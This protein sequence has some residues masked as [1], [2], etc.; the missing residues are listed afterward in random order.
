MRY[1]KRQ[2]GG[3]GSTW[4]WCQRNRSLL[5][6]SSFLA[7]MTLRKHCNLSEPQFSH[8]VSGNTSMIFMCLLRE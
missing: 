7:D 8:M 3:L 4:L 2:G 6:S 5:L 1:S